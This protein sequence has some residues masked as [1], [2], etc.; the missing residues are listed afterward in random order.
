LIAIFQ[1]LL[2]LVKLMRFVAIDAAQGL[3]GHISIITLASH[4]DY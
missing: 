2:P 4:P 3:R 1:T